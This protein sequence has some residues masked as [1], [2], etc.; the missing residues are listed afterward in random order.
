VKITALTTG[1][2]NVTPILDGLAACGNGVTRI[3]YDEMTRAEHRDLPRMVDEAEPDWVL[4]IGALY[5]H[6]G[7][8]VPR[9]E[10]LAEIGARHLMVHLC[11]DGAEAHWW[12]QLDE[13]Y[14]DGRFALMVN[15]DGT[16]TGPIGARGLTALCP[17]DASTFRDLPWEDRPLGCGFSGGMHGN[18]ASLMYPLRDRDLL[19]YRPRDSIGSYTAYR[20]FLE[21][22]RAGL[23]HA[24]TGGMVGGDHVKHRCLEIS[25]A[26]GIV[27]ETAGSPLR[28]WFDPG[29]DYLEYDGVEGAAAK[30]TWA[31]EHPDEAQTMAARMRAKV[32][33]RHSPAV[34]WSQVTER[35]G[36]SPALR[37]LPEVPYRNWNP[38]QIPLVTTIIEPILERP[39]HV[40]GHATILLGAVRGVNLVGHDGRVYTVPQDLGPMDFST[41][42][43]TRCPRVRGFADVATAQRAVLGGLRL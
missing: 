15:I 5:A 28:H 9:T 21:C 18:R 24:T 25:A 39:A 4:M 40:N 38:E 3:V 2:N 37:P 29:A 34:F 8:P 41:V 33:E 6:H 27:L 35:L 30:I 17:I 14:A 19:V 22:C 43:I 26:G 16:R 11:F 13:W 32:V 7:K 10:I 36:L 12:R 31:R 1:T 42:D 20:T 23:N